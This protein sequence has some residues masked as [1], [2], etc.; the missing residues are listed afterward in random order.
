MGDAWVGKGYVRV[1]S[2]M[3]DDVSRSA[4][5]DL[6]LERKAYDSDRRVEK[7]SFEGMWCAGGLALLW[8]PIA[9][10][11]VAVVS[12]K[13]QTYILLASFCVPAWMQLV[14]L[15]LARRVNRLRRQQPSEAR[16]PHQPTDT[17]TSPSAFS[18]ASSAVIVNP[19]LRPRRPH[20]RSYSFPL[21]SQLNGYRTSYLSD[22][23]RAR[24]VP[25]LSQHW[26]AG[27]VSGDRVVAPRS[28]FVR[29]L[30]LMFH[31]R[32]KLE[33]LPV[34]GRSAGDG[35]M[36]RQGVMSR[37]DVSGVER[38]AGTM[39]SER[40]CFVEASA[41]SLELQQRE[42]EGQLLE[43]S[44]GMTDV[45]LD[46]DE[47]PGSPRLPP[48][49]LRDHV[50]L[51]SPTKRPPV[52][53][54][55]NRSESHSARSPG[56]SDDPS[57]MGNSS[58][59]RLFSEILHMVRAPVH[60]NSSPQNLNRTPSE[61]RYNLINS[62]QLSL[63]ATANESTSIPQ[64]PD[65]SPPTSLSRNPSSSSTVSLSSISSRIRTS[66]RRQPSTS[67]S[68][69]SPR[70]KKIRS[71][72]FASAFG[73]ELNLLN[74]GSVEGSPS[75]ISEGGTVGSL[76]DSPSRAP[77]GY[78]APGEMEWIMHRRQTS[79]ADSI[80]DLREEVEEV[81]SCAEES[82]DSQHHDDEEL[83][84]EGGVDLAD[85]TFNDDVW[86]R[87]ALDTDD[88]IDSSMAVGEDDLMGFEPRR[89]V[90]RPPFLDT[91]TEEPEDVEVEEVGEC[92]GEGGGGVAKLLREHEMMFP[93]KTLSRIEEVTELTTRSSRM[94]LDSSGS[95]GSR[96]AGNIDGDGEREIRLGLP[97]SLGCEM[98]ENDA[99][100]GFG[101]VEEIEDDDVDADADEP[102][103]GGSERILPFVTPRSTI[104][105]RAAAARL[106]PPTPTRKFFATSPT[107]SKVTPLISPSPRS[108]TTRLSQLGLD[109]GI[110]SSSPPRLP[111]NNALDHSFELVSPPA[112]ADF[113]PNSHSPRRHLRKHSTTSPP[114]KKV[115]HK[116]SSSQKRRKSRLKG[117]AVMIA[118]HR[119][120]VVDEDDSLVR[121]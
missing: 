11:T 112:R 27:K 93:H 5:H 118:R 43:S 65:V 100:N 82:C 77:L 91:V 58:T 28:S 39:D 79:R 29:G 108:K 71:R 85:M 26:T 63:Y 35:G 97:L 3:G 105:R 31:P 37:L 121:Q 119:F 15:F 47:T 7:R 55:S 92:I 52:Q 117:V 12:S 56:F 83:R 53:D 87:H 25:Y 68:S 49:P 24:S 73:I 57:I 16:P 32:P 84:E 17:S 120:T 8:I 40:A 4:T 41:P 13:A 22:N 21:V 90:A 30:S 88:E 74:R 61:H 115:L 86:D 42:S 38:C 67:S 10:S 69:S 103:K 102:G 96:R 111:L 48:Q 34:R 94:M 106:A 23:S 66:L 33:V 70:I 110:W 104:R 18:A 80:V 6:L 116:A 72:T 113:Y 14:H 114:A 109:Q 76:M 2:P 64:Q 62:S 99:R 89:V 75:T 51:E 45:V 54:L 44:A 50:E 78:K 46:L 107:S 81:I 59:S 98:D 1:D 36:R 9:L 60:S 19:T 101:S 20:Y 95:A